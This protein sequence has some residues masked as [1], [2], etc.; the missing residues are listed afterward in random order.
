[1]FFSSLQLFTYVFINMFFILSFIYPFI[2]LFICYVSGVL[3]VIQMY[4][5]GV[6]PDFSYS[7]CGKPPPTASLIIKYIEKNMLS[8]NTEISNNENKIT[9]TEINE[10][11]RRD[12]VHA[13]R[14]AMN[15]KIENKDKEK[16]N[17]SI[18]MTG[19]SQSDYLKSCQKSLIILQNKVA[20]SKT[21]CKYVRAML[22]YVM[23][24]YVMLCYV[25]ICDVML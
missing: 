22:C 21:P 17:P 16:E 5:E 15:C 23:L 25:M 8:S 3:W 10:N 11:V 24:C 9:N 7:F 20:V 2:Y 12:T 13:I 14:A 1:M 18:K 4:C 19:L 6:C